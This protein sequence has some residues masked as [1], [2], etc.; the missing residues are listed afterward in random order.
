[1]MVTRKPASAKPEHA[2]RFTFKS[3][4]RLNF[5]KAAVLRIANAARFAAPACLQYN[6]R[7]IACLRMAPPLQ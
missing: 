3:A 7:I 5:T 6:F 2:R 1:M 4:S